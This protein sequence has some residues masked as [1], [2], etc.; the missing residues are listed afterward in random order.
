ML[1]APV[2]FHPLTFVSEGDDVLV[3]RSDIESYAVLPA[4]G[5]AL[6]QRLSVGLTPAEAANWY[7]TTY[8]EDVDVADF[9]DTLNQLGFVRKP[10]D[11]DDRPTGSAVPLQ[12]LGRLLF[13]PVALTCYALVVGGWLV[14]AMSHPELL[15]RPRNI[16]FTRSL[17]LVQL[18]IVFG[19]LPLLFLHEA[20]HV[21]AGRRLGLPSK[22]GFGTR[23]LVFVVFETRMNGLLTVARRKRYLPFLAG[24][25]LDIV[26]V[27]ALESVAFLLQ[28]S[29]GQETLAGRIVLALAFPTALRF[30]YQFIFF[31]QTDVYFVLSTALGCYDL[32]AATRAL[33]LNRIWRLLGRPDRL[34]EKNQWSERDLQVARWYQCVFA[35]GVCVLIVAWLFALLPVFTG[36]VRLSV[37]EFNSPV[38]DLHFWDTV[39]FVGVNAAQ[40]IFYFYIVIRN[41]IR[42]RR[43]RTSGGLAHIVATD[44]E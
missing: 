42:S 22:L 35:A 6:L 15:P 29:S 26:A 39:L 3:G 4:S 2:K 11:E 21:L 30:V 7:L 8:G 17:L 32:H 24:M 44:Q 20:Y 25:I 14:L 23:L 40:L 36:I 16:F 41:F 37:Q 19:Q 34:V 27:C 38:H 10:G 43:P 5:A 9:L 18:L 13:S 31:L 12:W 28:N 33:V 1:D